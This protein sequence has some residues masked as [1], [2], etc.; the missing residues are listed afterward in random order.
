MGGLQPFGRFR[1]RE[2][3]QHGVDTPVHRVRT[4]RPRG[5]AAEA[6]VLRQRVVAQ[7]LAAE[8]VPL[9]LVLQSEQH[10]AVLR[11][12][13][14]VGKDR[15]VPCA[16][17]RRRRGAVCAVI[18][19]ETHPL[20]HRFQHGH[21]DVV[22]AI[23]AVA[24]QEREQDAPMRGDACGDV[25]DGDAALRHGVGRA[26]DGQ[27][28]RFR[29]HQEIVG[30][31][32]PERPAGA[33]A[34]YGRG[35]QPL[36]ARAQGLVVEAHAGDGARREVLHEHVG[37]R[38]HAQE[39]GAVPRVLQIERDR[40]LGAVGP[41]EMARQPPRPR[42]VA[43]REIARS[44]PLHLD[45]PRALIRQQPRAIGRGDR[46]LQGNDEQAVQWSH[47]GSLMRTPPPPGPRATRRG[48]RPARPPPSRRA[49]RC[50]REGT[51][52]SP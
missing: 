13:G 34:G 30:L 14:A 24:R 1:R 18:H 48:S 15:R 36:V 35:D 11:L 29:L 38:D 31:A 17:A 43:P 49:P 4:L 25:D 27:K 26:G 37:T 5:I 10:R 28:A 40:F 46:L 32:R 41:S 3:G 23:R 33:E 20:R 50:R 19:R 2:R 51:V 45:D 16:R 47:E 52:L 22:A 44:R 39:E 8:G 7:N 9:A 42:I 12:V 6:R 21:L